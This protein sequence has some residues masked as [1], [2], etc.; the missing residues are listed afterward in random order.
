MGFLTSYIYWAPSPVI[1][2]IADSG[3][4]LTWYGCMWMLGLVVS[5]Q[6]GLYI[7][8]TDNR[9]TKELPNLFLLIMIPAFIGARL[10]HFLFYDFWALV[11][12][13][14]ILVVPPFEGFA[15]HGG[16]TGILVG[17]YIWCRNN[18]AQYLFVLDRLAIV[19]CVA[20][21]FI[22]VGNLFNSEII[23]LPATAPWAFVF[24]RVDGL[25]RHPTQLYEA[26][27]YFLLFFALLYMWRR[28]SFRL[29]PGFMLGIMLTALWSFRFFIEVYK[30]D[31]TFFS[32]IPW[33]NRSQILSLPFILS[34]LALLYFTRKVERPSNRFLGT[35]TD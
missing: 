4:F 12:K 6:V 1:F 17:V 15:S 9:Y 10:G 34:G 32:N 20:A 5:R 19:S 27:F 14:W 8:L 33:F 30:E 7:F 16:I 22:R 18:H 3:I 23:G 29:K 13:P 26:L 2:E 11:E 25:P 28:L 24:A 35:E 31:Q 21:G